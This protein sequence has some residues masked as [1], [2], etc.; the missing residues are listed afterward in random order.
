M[1]T[2]AEATPT[3]TDDEPSGSRARSGGIDAYL[4]GR[5]DA[6]YA[7][8]GGVLGAVFGVGGARYRAA[9]EALP[10]QRDD[11]LDLTTKDAR[12]LLLAG[13]QRF[14]AGTPLHPDQAP[15]RRE[16]LAAGQKP[17]AAVL[18]CADSRVSPEVLFDQGLGDL[19]VVR[20]A[21]QVIDKAVLGSLLY[22][23][24]H[25]EV[26][27]LVVLGHSACGAVKATVEALETKAKPT[28]TAIDDL[29]SAITPAVHEADEIGAEGDTILEVAI[30]I[31]VE[32]AVESLK[33]TK[34]IGEAVSKR[35]LK[36]VGAIYDLA[37]GEV[38][39]L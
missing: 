11:A 12:E 20:S 26:P 28:G 2:T 33:Q 35:T 14:V 31:N 4:P 30:S 9:A 6:L 29:V 37:T 3:D 17:F 27:L 23:V 38:D 22:G 1:T 15:D 19:F 10:P 36:V 13:N 39:W 5:R 7:L 34:H 25:L 8:G 21:G 18:S 16:V 24:E 32:R